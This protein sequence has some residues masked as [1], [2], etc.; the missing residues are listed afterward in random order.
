[1][2]KN[3]ILSVLLCGFLITA[4]NEKKEETKPAEI[5]KEEGLVTFVE[6]TKEQF[7]AVD[8]QLGKIEL[9]NISTTIKA[10]GHLEVPPQNKAQV[11]SYVGAVV[12]SIAVLEGSKVNKGQTLAVLEHPDFIKLQENYIDAKNNLSF[13]EKEYSRQKEL[14]DNDAGTGKIY[15]RAESDY[16]SAKSRLNSLASQL[17]VLSVNINQLNRGKI[18][19]SIVLKAPITGYIGHIN[20]NTGGY[21]EPNTP[22]FEIIDNSQIHCDLLVYEKDIFKVKVGQ[23]IHFSI[24][25]M[26]DHQGEHEG[27]AIEGEIFGVNKS[28]EGDSKAISVHARIKNENHALIPGMYVN[29]LI[30]VGQNKTT[31]VPS[32]AVFTTDGKQFVFIRNKMTDCKIH[33]DC[34]AH[35]FCAPSEDCPEHPKCEQHEHS[36]LAKACTK[37]P[38]CEAHEKCK[39]V[40][41]SKAYYF[42]MKEVRKGVTDLGYT[43]VAFIDEVPT[44]ATVVSKGAFYLLSKSKTGGQM[45]ACGH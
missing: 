33:K 1:M 10:S 35:E 11:S 36:P 24:T 15:Q 45:E 12:K 37:H 7:E 26:P 44:D 41:N 34:A 21:A 2:Y 23:K 39:A 13:L 38:E 27:K 29:A 40:E 19:S 5:P 16:K 30:D 9:Q 43:E 31:V 25:N 17:R 3:K 6:L 22:L 18:T 28:F 8:I 4:C 14:A 32:E 42:T 20:A